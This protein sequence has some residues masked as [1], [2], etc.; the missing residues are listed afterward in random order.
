MKKIPYNR[1]AAVNYASAWALKRSS[2]YYNFDNIGGDCTNFVSQCLYAGCRVMNY[3]S[4][5][6]WYYISASKRSPSWTGV[7]FLQSF[8]LTNHGPGPYARIV[9]LDEI[10]PG[11]IIQLKNFSGNF[12]HSLFTVSVSDGIYIASHT[13]DSLYRR[14]DTYSYAGFA[15]LHI[16]GVR[17][18]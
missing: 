16:E 11:D 4:K 7:S 10:L 18:W 12:Y 1:D 5:E 14:L 15:A 17:S 6:G 9:S 13:S 8:L 3:S 2:D